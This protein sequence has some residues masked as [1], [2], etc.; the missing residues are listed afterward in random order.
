MCKGELICGIADLPRI[1]KDHTY[2]D[3]MGF[4]VYASW[5]EEAAELDAASIDWAKV[6]PDNFVYRL[7]QEA[8][9][10]RISRRPSTAASASS[11]R[12]RPR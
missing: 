6:G 10:A 12:S 4:K 2:L 9:P 3:K 5:Q 11:C 7:S 8:G 1:R